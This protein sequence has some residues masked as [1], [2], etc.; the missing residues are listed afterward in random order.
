MPFKFNPITGNLDYYESGSAGDDELVKLSATDAT[1]GYLDAKL[2]EG[3]QAIQFDTTDDTP[4]TNAEGLLQWNATDGTLDLGMDGGEITL[5]I[6]QEMFTKVIN[7]TG[8]TISNGKAVYFNGRQGN[9]PTIALAK[10]DAM[11]TSAVMGMTTQDIADDTEGFIT[12]MG[13]VRQIKTD[14]AGWA[15]GD[16]LYVSTTTAGELTNVEPDAP[17]HSDEIGSVGV[18]GGAGIGSILISIRRHRDITQSS[19]IN[20]TPLDTTGQILVWDETN[21]YFDFDHFLH[22]T[23]E[24]TGFPNRTDTTLAFNDSTLE[25]SIT[26][27]G[28]TFDYYR[29]YKKITKTGAQTVTISDTTGLHFIYFDYNDDLV[30]S[31]TPWDFSNGKVFVALLVWN[32][33]INKYILCDE[34]HGLTMD[35]STHKYLHETVGT[36]YRSG[37]GGT[38][39]DTTVSIEAGH[40]YDEDL[41]LSIGAQTNVRV[42]YKNGTADFEWTDPQTIYY[43]TSGGSLYYNNGNTLTP[44]DANKY[45][46]VWIFATNS[47]DYPIISVMGQRQDT[48]LADAKLNN[49]YNSLS[50]TGLPFAEFK[51]LYRVILRNDVTPYEETQDL[52][53]VSNLPS[54]T[55]LATDH[56]TLTNIGVNTHTEIDTALTRLADTSGTNTGD[57]DISGKMNIDQTTPQT[58]VGG[59]TFPSVGVNKT[60]SADNG[61]EILNKTGKQALR[62]QNPSETNIAFSTYKTGDSQVRF[63]FLGDGKMQWGPGNATADTTLYRSAANTLKTDDDFVANN[64]TAGATVSGTNTGDQ[65]LSG[66]VPYT[67]ATGAV[68]LG[69][70]TLAAGFITANTALSMNNSSIIDFYSDAGI[71]TVGSIS[72]QAE[73][74]LTFAGSSYDQV[75][76]FTNATNNR[77][78]T[79]PD[80]TGTI[81]LTSDLPTGQDSIKSLYEDRNLGTNLVKVAK[82]LDVGATGE[83]D[84]LAVESP[85]IIRDPKSGKYVM[86]YVGWTTI[87]SEIREQIGIA[88]SDD[89]INWTKDAGNPILSWSGTASSPDEFGVTGPVLLWDDANDRYVMFYI[90]LTDVG[91]EGG[92]PTICV[93][94]TPSLTS[95]SWTRHGQVIDIDGTGWRAVAVYHASVVKRNKIYYM[96]FNTKGADLKEYIGYATATDLLG[97]WTVDEANSPIISPVDAT[98]ESSKVGDPSVRRVGDMWVMDYFGFNG[99]VAS[100]GIAVTSDY[101]FPLGWVKYSGNPIL[102]PSVPYDLKYAHK[103]FVMDDGGSVLH[104]YTCVDSSDARA[105]A[106]AVSDNP[107][108][109]YNPKPVYDGFN[110]ADGVLGATDS[111]HKWITTVSGATVSSGVL[112]WAGTS[113][114]YA[115][116]NSRLNN[117]FT[118][119]FK[120]VAIDTDTYP[121]GILAR[122]VDSTHYLKFYRQESGT[123]GWLMSV[124]G[125]S[126]SKQSSALPAAGTI[127]SLKCINNVYTIYHD[128]VSVA[129][130]TTAANNLSTN[131]GLAL[132]GNATLS[133]DNISIRSITDT[134]IDDSYVLPE[135]FIRGRRQ[136][137]TTNTAPI[138]MKVQMGW[139]WKLGAAANF[140]SEAVTFPVAFTDTPIVILSSAGVK[141]GSDPAS[142]A[143]LTGASGDIW[144]ANSPSTTGFTANVT[145]KDSSNLSTTVRYGYSW[146]AI[147]KG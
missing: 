9:R 58:M 39:D 115:Y 69:A 22:V 53:S 35:W 7:K 76:D 146:I 103:P 4:I 135:N 56:T 57:Q 98:W 84:D 43:Y 13:Y 11:A 130:W 47:V 128:G 139:G 78:F 113:D 21:K 114:G 10:G 116:V 124:D 106:L 70:N 1:A 24:A 5:Q 119:Q 122:Y 26:P 44:V 147:G 66:L 140:M 100:D 99:T 2:Q 71:T 144:Y 107:L 29:A 102:T 88:W 38:F 50:L 33:T 83:W 136:D 92:T 3:I 79:F 60:A 6:G 51:V 95:P 138:G 25:F 89:K 127:V 19:D 14:Y 80:A 55:Y 27:T 46:A 62:I 31:L 37:L 77:T 126:E 64:I 97:P 85:T 82:V 94:T 91:M 63:T 133:I 40:I 105:I 28:A 12:T 23:N 59:F 49:T 143:E 18:V 86:A 54:G 41:D 108:S 101:D 32:T 48:L 125:S 96:F 132:I 104:Y 74:Q 81:A 42:M 20:G 141:S 65:D 111:G 36:R 45:V 129:S 17:H 109:S 110:R 52:R 90:G 121:I 73:N 34:R 117:N 120:I 137:N 131:Q 15:E 61:I 145:Q 93:A 16:R 134:G 67:G 123:P 142:L 72:V 118:I 8:T 112:A 68:D 30:A 87:E 75:L